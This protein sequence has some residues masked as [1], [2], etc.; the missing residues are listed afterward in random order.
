MARFTQDVKIEALK[1]AP[2][3]ADLSRKELVEVA[4][5]TDEIAVPAD[6][7]LAKEGEVGHEFFVVVDGEAEFTRNGRK[8]S[9][10]QPV[11]F[12]GSTDHD[13]TEAR[14]PDEHPA[15]VRSVRQNGP[16][17]S[18]GG[19]SGAPGDG[20]RPAPS[21]PGVP[22]PVMVSDTRWVAWTQDAA[23]R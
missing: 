17:A 6:T 12:F 8:L 13:R 7:V 5:L 11:E 20:W 18:R 15:S 14:T 23:L 10:G 9:L 19:S 16:H 2:L 22:Q 4:K 1:R 21:T 3:F